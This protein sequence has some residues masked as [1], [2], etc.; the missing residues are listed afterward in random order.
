MSL[1]VHDI[2][3]FDPPASYALCIRFS[4]FVCLFVCLFG[5]FFM[6]SNATV[7]NIS[8]ISWRSVLLVT[9]T[10]ENRRPVDSH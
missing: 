6:V 4:L 10:G 1:T 8:V 5:V 7:N 9:K 2:A 3:M